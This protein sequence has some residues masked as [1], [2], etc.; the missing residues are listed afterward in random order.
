MGHFWYLV[1]DM[2]MFFFVPFF[3]LAFV[4][5]REFFKNRRDQFFWAAPFTLFAVF[6]VIATWENNTPQNF[7]FEI[8]CQNVCRMCFFVVFHM[9]WSEYLRFIS[10][11]F[12]NKSISSRTKRF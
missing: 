2:Q 4:N 8:M 6:S 10:L 11:W 3:V 9:C 7:T 5:E 12:Q 1:V